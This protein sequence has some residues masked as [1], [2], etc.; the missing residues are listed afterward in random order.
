MFDYKIIGSR[1]KA[2]RKK[3]GFSQSD[4]AEI[5]NVSVPYISKIET[6][7][8]VASL[9]RLS[10]LAD[11]LSADIGELISGANYSSK[12]YMFEELSSI[13]EDCSAEER[14]FAYKMLREFK[15]MYKDK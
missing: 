3:K 12:Y 9:R 11:I 4:V 15:G 8:A 13:L 6:G 1:L 5:L 14:T 2:A 7:R 10:E